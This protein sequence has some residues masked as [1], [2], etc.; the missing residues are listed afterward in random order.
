MKKTVC[1]LSLIIQFNILLLPAPV[2]L[3]WQAQKAFCWDEDWLLEMLSGINI[4]QVED[5]KY[6]KHINNSIVIIAPSC[7]DTGFDEYF[8]RMHKLNYKFGIIHLSDET[9][10]VSTKSYQYAQFVFRNYWHEKFEN[11]AHITTIPLGYKTTF[12]RNNSRDS[13]LKAKREYSWSFAGQI[14]EKPTRYQMATYL[15]SIPN[16]FI[17]EIFIWRDHNSLSTA[18]YRDLMLK[19]Y[20]IPSPMGYCNLDSFRIYEALECGCIP[21]VEKTPYDY[22]K[23]YYGDHPFI[24]VNSW[25]EAVPQ[26][27]ELLDN[28]IE[29]E[30]RR[31]T[32]YNWWQNY[33]KQLSSKLT[34][35]IKSHLE[36]EN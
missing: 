10:T 21:I 28:P 18:D 6:E 11:Q 25:D 22:F 30:K 14:T 23:L 4:V 24:S 16:H 13:A 31:L 35:I 29:L 7:Q 2:S 20:F 15:K 34:T 26:I 17:H 32:C 1:I 33:K 3:V 19:S 8:E 36:C 27:K 9:Y 5:G 12:W